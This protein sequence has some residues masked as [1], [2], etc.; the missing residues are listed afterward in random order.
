MSIWS[1]KSASIQERASPLKFD[2]FLWKSTNF[3]ASNLSTKV[4]HGPAREVGPYPRPP[5]AP[6]KPAPHG[7]AKD[8]GPS[9]LKKTPRPASAGLDIKYVQGRS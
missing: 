2:H 6:G 5:R 8:L 4:P 1:Q 3:S 7:P 9:S